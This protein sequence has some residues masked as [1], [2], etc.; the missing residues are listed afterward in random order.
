MCSEDI[1]IVLFALGITVVVVIAVPL[2]S[3]Q[4][5]VDFTSW[6]GVMLVIS[7]GFFAFGILMML[8]AAMML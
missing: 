6:I 1:D 4:T 7:L 2:M 3:C 5:K 8:M